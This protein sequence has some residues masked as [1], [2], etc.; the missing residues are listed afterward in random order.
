MKEEF[1]KDDI[2]NLKYFLLMVIEDN[3]QSTE[4]DF[5]LA[6]NLIRKLNKIKEKK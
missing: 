2:E 5:I 1:T 6:E 4:D 3:L